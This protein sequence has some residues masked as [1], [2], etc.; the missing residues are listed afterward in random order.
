MFDFNGLEV[1]FPP[2]V[3]VATALAFDRAGVEIWLK[4]DGLLSALGTRFET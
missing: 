1:R 2:L 3:D 4:A